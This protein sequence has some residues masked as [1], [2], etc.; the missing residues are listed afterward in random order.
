MTH[1]QYV[2]E[3]YSLTWEMQRLIDP[4]CSDSEFQDLIEK[5]T[6]NCIDL[7]ARYHAQENN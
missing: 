3:I 1:D 6:K 7:R 2:E 4:D 5:W